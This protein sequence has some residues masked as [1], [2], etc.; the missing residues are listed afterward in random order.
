VTKVLEAYCTLHW[1]SEPQERVLATARDVALEW[2]ARRVVLDLC[3]LHKREVDAGK[4][5]LPDL[6]AAG[7]PAAPAGAARHGPPRVSSRGRGKTPQPTGNEA[8][9]IRLWIRAGNYRNRDYPEFYAYQRGQGGGYYV[10]VPLL[11]EWGEL[12]EPERQRWRDKAAET[13]RGRSL[14]SPIP[15]PADG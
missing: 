2:D 6:L 12:P 7:D 11:L 9:A 10:P 1:K 4:W 14:P 3:A 13:P 8:D 5:S 15:A